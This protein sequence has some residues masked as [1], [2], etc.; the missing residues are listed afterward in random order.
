MQPIF[1]NVGTTTK[2]NIVKQLLFKYSP[3]WPLFLLF[4]FLG[5]AGAWLYLRYQNPVY[6][7][8]ATILIKDEKKVKMIQGLLNR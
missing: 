6:E 1:Q 8:T 7:S 2:E 3:Y 4:M 5:V